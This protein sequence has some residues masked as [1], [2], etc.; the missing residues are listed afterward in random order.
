[1]KGYYLWDWNNS[2]TVKFREGDQFRS[3][4]YAA[5]QDAFRQFADAKKRGIG[6]LT[7]KIADLQDDLDKLKALT[8]ADVNPR[9]K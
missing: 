3:E 6:E 8:V 1:M 9:A 4:E 7:R 2:G 5:E